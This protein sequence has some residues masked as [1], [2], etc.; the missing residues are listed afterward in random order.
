MN[1][2]APNH[3]AREEETGRIQP[4]SMASCRQFFFHFTTLFKLFKL[5]IKIRLVIALYKSYTHL[6]A[7]NI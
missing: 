6:L 4:I 5:F 1:I 2:E 7:L 3:V